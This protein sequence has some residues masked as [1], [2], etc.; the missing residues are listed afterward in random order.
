MK[1]A[2]NEVR[3]LRMTVRRLLILVAALRVALDDERAT[4]AHVHVVGRR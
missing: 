3:R 2:R 4:I 1:Q